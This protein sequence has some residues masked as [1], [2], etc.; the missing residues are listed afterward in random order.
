MLI[1]QMKHFKPVLIGIY[2]ITIL[3]IAGAMDYQDEINDHNYYVAAVCSGEI[4]DHKQLN[5]EC[6]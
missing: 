3:G 6:L 5:P 4:F 2:F 1:I